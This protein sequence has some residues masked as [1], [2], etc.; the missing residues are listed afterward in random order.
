[1]ALEEG[2]VSGM[3]ARANGDMRDRME[4]IAAGEMEPSV[5]DG[6]GYF[7]ILPGEYYTS[8]QIFDKEL[9]KVF[10]RQWLYA[11]QVSQLPEP[12]DFYVRDIGPESLIITRDQ[13][14]DLRAFFNVCAHRGSRIC[15][16]GESGNAKHFVCPYHRWSYGVDGHLMGVPGARDG[17]DINYADWG[18]HEAHCDSY[19]GSIFVYLA[20]EE[21]PQGLHEFVSAN[22]ADM[23]KLAAVQPERTK[24]AASRVYDIKANWKAMMENNAEC[25]HCPG[26]HPSLC[27]TINVQAG[28][29]DVDHELDPATIGNYLPF[30]NGA[31]TMSPDGNWLCKKPLGGS[32]PE[33]QF[34]AGFVYFPNFCGMSYF[35]DYGNAIIIEPVAVDRTRLRCEWFVHE[36]AVEGVDYDVETLIE[37]WDK[38]NMEDK[39]LAENNYSGA[40][41]LRFKPGPNIVSRE[42]M[43]FGALISY[44][45]MLDAP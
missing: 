37:V 32:W 30:K 4:R 8:Q 27:A 26:S 13:N 17:K 9:R 34:S 10:S 29:L 42:G 11:G 33:G 20:D 7:T 16:A 24:I 39:V 19:F 45:E 3:L 23:E 2:S 43:M 25:Y 35:A 21:P 14:G 18:L 5:I 41:S 44:L 6:D 36:D 40:K 15:K 12:G 38:T 1:M 31:N 28:F 22:T